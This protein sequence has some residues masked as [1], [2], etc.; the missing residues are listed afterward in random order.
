MSSLCVGGVGYFFANKYL[1]KNAEDHLIVLAEKEALQISSKLEGIEQYVK[2]LNYVVLEGIESD[3]TIT[4]DSTRDYH[5]EQNLNFIRSTIRN[6]SGAVAVYLRYNPKLTPPTSGI[7]MSKV[8][9]KSGIKKLT[10]TDFSKYAPN[11]IEHV[12]WYYIPVENGKPIWM[13]PY[14]NKNVDIYMISYVIPLFKFG[15]EIGVIGVDVDFNYITS[16]ISNIKLFKTGFAYLEDSEGKI[17][18]HPTLKMG[19]TPV[20]NGDN[21]YIRRP[22]ANGMKFVIVAPKSEFYEGQLELTIRI[23]VLAIL[24]ILIFARISIYFANSITRPLHKLTKAANQMTSGNLDV[25]FDTSSSDEIGELSKSFS[26]ARDYI[27]EYLGYVKGIAYKDSLTGVRNKTAYDN[28]VKD[29]EKKISQHEIFD[30]GI[31]AL[32]VNRLKKINDTY[33]HDHGNMLLINACHLI[34]K[35]FTHSPVFRIGG[36]EFIVFLQHDDYQNREQLMQL[37]QEN[38]AKTEAEASTPWESVS[39]AAGIASYDAGRADS[40]L[41]VEKRADEAM[42]QNK[43]DMKAERDA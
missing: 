2:T 43:K 22:L 41:A 3:S 36:D 12:G 33:G 37:L 27:K 18:Y 20:D 1:E 26:A 15:E 30:F 42:Y 14:E 40:V 31:V 13:A 9:K 11:D 39:I 7:F 25:S 24:I 32:D 16:E 35:T 6:T 10:P 5:T 17:A 38:M 4:I 19:D 8:S 23:T 29:I 28:F 34:C 21:I